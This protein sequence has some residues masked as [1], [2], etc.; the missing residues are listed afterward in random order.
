M[1]NAYGNLFTHND[2]YSDVCFVLAKPVTGSAGQTHGL[3]IITWL[4]RVFI[5]KRDKPGFECPYHDRPSLPNDT[6][7]NRF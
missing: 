3:F 1:S 4:P 2:C 6:K 5:S 7:A